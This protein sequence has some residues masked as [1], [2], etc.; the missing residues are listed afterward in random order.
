MNYV[1]DVEELLMKQLSGLKHLIEERER[2]LK[3]YKIECE[4]CDEITYVASYK[5]PTFCSMCGRRAEPEEVES[6]E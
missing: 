1:L 2:S 5:E 4:E 3:D 6:S